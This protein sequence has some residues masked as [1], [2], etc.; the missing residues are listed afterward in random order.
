MLWQTSDK[1][2]V[3]NNITNIAANK[4]QIKIIS[5][6]KNCAWSHTRELVKS[7]K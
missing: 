6:R 3:S 2:R 7:H 1:E 5:N 4:Y